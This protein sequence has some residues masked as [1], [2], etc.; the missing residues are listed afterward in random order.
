MPTDSDDDPG[1]R[2]S[3]PALMRQWAALADLHMDDR[4]TWGSRTA[5]DSLVTKIR[6]SLVGR[7][8]HTQVGAHRLVFTLS[9]LHARVDPLGASAGQADEVSLTAQEVEYGGVTI[10]QATALLGNVH[11]RVRLRP[12][13]VSAPVDLVLK[14]TNEQVSAALAE[15]APRLAVSCCRG[16]RL[17]LHVRR[18]PSWGWLDVI[19]ELADGQVTVRPVVLGRGRW[20]RRLRR[21]WP[22]RRIPLAMPAKGRIVSLL[23][24]PDGLAVAIRLDEWRFDYDQIFKLIRTSLQENSPG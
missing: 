18:H 3:L 24:E 7:R 9:E 23:V 11:T 17:R 12:T 5:L 14:A 16:S 10:A 21:R 20:E 4:A 13:L 15:R 1:S 22:A 6:S 2:W 19:P 8:V